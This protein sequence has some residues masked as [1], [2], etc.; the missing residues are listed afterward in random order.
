[1]AA[2]MEVVTPSPAALPP[3]PQEPKR[4]EEGVGPSPK[5]SP[6]NTMGGCRNLSGRVGAVFDV[7]GFVKEGDS[8]P[9][10]FRRM[11]Q[12]L[13]ASGDTTPAIYGLL[14]LLRADL[15]LGK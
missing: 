4:A 13:E 8:P 7:V 6:I 3:P 11:K 15:D 2:P 10:V 12:R 14:A 1:M 5:S 9:V